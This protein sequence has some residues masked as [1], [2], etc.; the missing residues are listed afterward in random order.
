MDKEIAKI[1]KQK[2]L[3]IPADKTTNNYLVPPEK[4]KALID[5]EIHKSY[6]KVHP[7]NVSNI[8]KQHSKT[9]TELDIDDRVMA[10]TP[11][12]AF[13]SLKDHLNFIIQPWWR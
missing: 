8:T 6:K 13:I 10:T 2:D 7:K 9:V 5:K 4:Y 3:I 1:S 12:N 11:R